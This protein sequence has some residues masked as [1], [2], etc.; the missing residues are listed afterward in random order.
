M[1]HA[2]CHNF[3]QLA[4]VRTFLGVMEASIN[5]GSM[6]IFTM[7]YKRSEQPLRMGIWIGSAGLSY[8]AGGAINYGIGNISGSL[9]SWR[10]MFL[11]N[12]STTL[13]ANYH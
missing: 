2:A 8:V 1:C 3:A 11:V 9:S 10:I 7:W 13:N 6:L 5:P 12:F 4:A